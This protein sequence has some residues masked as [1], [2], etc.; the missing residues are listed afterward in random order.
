MGGY[1]LRRLGWSLVVVAAIVAVTFFATYILPADPA[2]RGA[3]LTAFELDKAVYEVAYEQAY[4]PDWVGIPM[5]AVRRMT[6][7][8]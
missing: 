3:V 2:S 4:R 8:G 7:A 1:I 5:Q 6:E